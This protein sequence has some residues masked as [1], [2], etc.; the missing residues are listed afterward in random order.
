[1]TEV[2]QVATDTGYAPASWAF[3]EE[4]TRVFDDMLER[5]VPEFGTMRELVTEIACCFQQDHTDIV[6]L[7]CSRGGAVAPL[8][9]RFGAHNRYFL[10]DV[11]EPMLEAARQRF[12]GYAQG[13]FGG[14]GIMRIEHLDLREKYPPV[15]ASV[16]LCV[17]TLQFTPIEYRQRI[18]RDV[19]HHTAPKGALILVEKVL[20]AN[21]E[22]D[23]ALVDL[24]Y[25][26]KRRNGY[27]EDQIQRKRL[28]LEGKLVPVT[29]AW[30]EELL[31]MA[32]F[33]YVDCFWRCLNF[34]G[35]VAIKGE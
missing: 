14:Q 10:C 2:V 13:P 18:L 6:D 20:G 35:W 30:N 34:A 33:R 8:L 22:L 12:G 21:A 11:S 7:G 1:V 16:T 9:D 26:H 31:R 24:Y 32:G 17:L 15:S 19:Y 28:S 3:D 4:V 5:S 29:A 25:D 27:T 23:A